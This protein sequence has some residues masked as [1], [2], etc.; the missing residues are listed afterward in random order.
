MK[1][2]LDFHASAMKKNDRSFLLRC[3]NAAT[4][5]LPHGQA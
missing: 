3:K 2:P 1:M 5:I 4:G